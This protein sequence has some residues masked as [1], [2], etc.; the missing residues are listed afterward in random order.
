MRSYYNTFHKVNAAVFVGGGY[1]ETR[2]ALFIP[3]CIRHG[4]AVG[5]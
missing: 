2:K 3:L 4:L 5:A 1:T